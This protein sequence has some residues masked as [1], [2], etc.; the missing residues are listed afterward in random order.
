MAI[1]VLNDSNFFPGRN[2]F[3]GRRKSTLG[4]S[5]GPD[6]VSRYLC[7]IWGA[8]RDQDCAATS[9]D[10]RE[11]FHPAWRGVFR[12]GYLTWAGGRGLGSFLLTP[13]PTHTHTLTWVDI[14]KK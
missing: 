4:C 13:P 10:V 12:V 6:D 8:P 14:R 5:G 1:Y 2:I 9:S 3:S 7:D 11:I